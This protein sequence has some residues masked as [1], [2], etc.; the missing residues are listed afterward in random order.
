MYQAVVVVGEMRGLDPSKQHSAS[1]LQFQQP[2]NFPNRTTAFVQV[3]M[4]Q[5]PQ[6]QQISGNN[7]E[8]QHSPQS[9]L[10]TQAH[11]QQAISS[12][13]QQQ[14]FSDSNGNSKPTIVSP[15]HS[16]LGSFSPRST[17]PW[18]TMSTWCRLGSEEWWCRTT[19]TRLRLAPSAPP[20]LAFL[21]LLSWQWRSRCPHS[22]E[23]GVVGYH[24]RPLNSFNIE[25]RDGGCVK[26]VAVQRRR[27]WRS[28]DGFNVAA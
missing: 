19:S 20:W 5:Q 23:C 9:Q 28:H 26:K 1:I 27:Y 18:P 8:N 6:H 15:L 21:F 10:Q 24:R 22:D 2:Q 4:S 12:L 16:I 17:L 11:L 3:Q 14:N 13:C 25:A 7:Q